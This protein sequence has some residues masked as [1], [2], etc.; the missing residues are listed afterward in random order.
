MKKIF[1]II[2]LSFI[3]QSV[4]SQQK[5]WV[6]FT[7]KA[8]TSFNPYKYFDK[9][10]I[11]RRVKLGISLFDSTDFPVNQN[12]V[13]EIK[14]NVEELTSQ[15]RWFNG[16]AVWAYHEQIQ[17]IEKFSFVRSV[18]PI[19][20]ST[21][22]ASVNYDTT[23]SDYND[24]LLEKQLLRMQGDKFVENGYDGT[25]MR[26]AIFDAGFSGADESPVF[27]HIRANNRIIKTYDFT[28]KKEYVYHGSKHGT[29]VWSCIAGKIGDKQIGLATGAEFLLA[30]TEIA[31]EP[32]SEEENWLAAVEWADKNGADIVNSSLGYT[33]HR[34]FPHQMDGHT[35]FVV[36]A[37]NLAAHKGLLVLNA[38]G[39]DGDKDW[40]FLGTPADAD[41]ILSIGGTDP[42]TDYHTSFSSYGPTAEKK[43][44][45][46]VVAYGHAIVATKNGL[47]KSQGTSFSTPLVT[48]FAACAW[49][50]NP[51]LTNMQMKKEIEN[52]G[53]LFPYYDYAHGFGVPQASYFTEKNI[54][55]PDTT[56]K[57]EHQG[58]TLKIIVDTNYIDSTNNYLYYH[59]ENSEGY[60]VKYFLIDVYQSEAETI[61]LNEIDN[62]SIIRV[63]FKGFT[64]IFE[65][66]NR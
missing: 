12:Y 38:M 37:A 45:P 60:L 53:D 27:D 51:D 57:F 44:K 17:K 13:T 66:L 31:S 54:P 23:L 49:Q 61:L 56:F 35:S 55:L 3:L 28:K 36:K 48:G 47:T 65:Q 7:D 2:I 16:V 11:A 26:I 33:H 63:H 34:Y 62:T 6:F 21:Y 15:T 10:A 22:P 4:F 1:L 18:Q 59:F 19:I 14:Q 9:K 64:D 40:K 8:E 43:M 24:K 41:S 25:G 29:M 58:N 20:F 46:N 50:T 52:S 5:Y 30:K 32:F 42:D 39:N